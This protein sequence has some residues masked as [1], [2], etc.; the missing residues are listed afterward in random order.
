MD[1]TPTTLDEIAGKI[2]NTIHPE[3]IIIF[4]SPAYSE[5]TEKSDIGILVIMETAKREIERIVVVN[6]LIREHRK[7]IDFNIL[8]KTPAEVKHRLEICDP[9]ISETISI[10][11]VLA[12]RKITHKTT[13]PLIT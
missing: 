9:V 2:V 5:P 4:G 10:G 6:K 1:E 3:K 8:V 7:K 13:K 11:K 12:R